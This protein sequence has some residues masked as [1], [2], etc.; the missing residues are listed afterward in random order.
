VKNNKCCHVGIM[1]RDTRQ[2]HQIK[3][4]DACSEVAGVKRSKK[5]NAQT[6]QAEF[7]WS[8]LSTQLTIS[9]H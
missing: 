1:V 8:A 7:Q 9:R 5:L 2:T 4:K 3:K 6:T